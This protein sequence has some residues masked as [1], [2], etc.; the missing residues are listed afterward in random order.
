MRRGGP[1]LQVARIVLAGVA[2]FLGARFGRRQ[3]PPSDGVPDEDGADPD[4]PSEDGQDPEG[5]TS[6]QPVRRTTAEK[7]TLAAS[8]VIVALLVGAALWEQF[9]LDEPDGSWVE[10]TVAVDR[11]ERRGGL[12]YVPYTVANRGRDPAENVTVVFEFKQGEETVEES[13]AD[14]AFLS[15]SGEVEGELVT[16]LDLATHT[17]EAR[18]G[19]LQVP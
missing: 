1:V 15:N 4:A 17:I 14:V 19:T 8:V 9:V 18:V 2:A 7:V 3:Q 5:A 11:A 12:T 10:V 6:E 16:A 13:T